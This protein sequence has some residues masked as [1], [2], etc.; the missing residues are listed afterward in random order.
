MSYRE[1]NDDLDSLG[2]KYDEL[3]KIIRDIDSDDAKNFDSSL[4]RENTIRELRE[5]E[6]MIKDA[7]DRLKFIETLNK[8]LKESIDEQSITMS[9]L[10]EAGNKESSMFTADLCR[11]YFCF[12]ET[13][14]WKIKILHTKISETGD[15]DDITFSISGENAC[16]YLC[17]E[18]GIHRFQQIPPEEASGCIHTSVVTVN[19][20]PVLNET[21]ICLINENISFLVLNSVANK[22]HGGIRTYNFPQNRVTDHRINLTLYKLD[23]IMQGN[24]EELFSALAE[25]K[26]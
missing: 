6:I 13:K 11:M 10:S 7:K 3:K 26:E 24:A 22:S 12:A 19:T 1:I 18:S 17:H 25:D 9:I 23:L 16:K 2:K 5:L 4:I 20:I 15:F 8:P 14:S 21:N